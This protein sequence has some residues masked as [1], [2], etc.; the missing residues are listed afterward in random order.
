MSLE[1]SGYPTQV[2]RDDQ[3]ALPASIVT[4]GAFDGVHRGHQA[5]I[6]QAVAEARFLDL[7]SVVWT[8]DPPPKVFFGRA[9]QFAPVSEKPARIAQLGPDHIVLAHFCRSYAQR[10]PDAFLADLSRIGPR[11]IHVGSDF[12]FGANQS[13]DVSLLARHFDVVLA[14][15]VLCEDGV[16]IS[17]TRMRDLR[18]EGRLGDVAALQGEIPPSALLCGALLTK[19]LRLEESCDVWC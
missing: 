5:L 13:G 7:P 12:R 18:K 11:R 10:S 8:F 4:I 15:P 1:F 16:T 9:Q 19:D 2:M 14:P 3:L 17:S 6:S